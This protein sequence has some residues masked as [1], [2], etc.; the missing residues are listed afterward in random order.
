MSRVFGRAVV[1]TTIVLLT[2][3]S[4][5]HSWYFLLSHSKMTCDAWSADACSL[6]WV[7]HRP[8]VSAAPG[9]EKTVWA[10]LWP[11]RERRA[12]GQHAIYARKG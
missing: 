9:M 4:G 12:L 11:G 3:F 1:A 2:G 8:S 7:S 10:S 6:A 5:A